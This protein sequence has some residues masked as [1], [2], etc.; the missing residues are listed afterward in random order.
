MTGANRWAKG[1]QRVYREIGRRVRE[2]RQDRELTQADLGASA[3]MTRANVQHIE[4][5][6]IRIQVHTLIQFASALMVPVARLLPKGAD[7]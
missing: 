4:A 3:D 2:V 7:E 5:G 6:L 1:E